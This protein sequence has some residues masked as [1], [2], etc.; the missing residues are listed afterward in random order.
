VAPAT[1]ERL[2][3]P[4]YDRLLHGPDTRT[5]E[6]IMERLSDE[7]RRRIP[8]GRISA[9]LALLGAAVGAP[10]ANEADLNPREALARSVV[11]SISHIVASGGGVILG[12]GAAIVLTGQPYAY[13]VRLDGPPDRRVRQGMELEGVDEPTARAHQADADRAWN[14]FGL[15]VLDRNPA[16]PRLYHLVIDSTA[17]PLDACS[18]LISR[19]ATVFWERSTPA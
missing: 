5:P 11:S 2:D 16:D 13:H 7:E 12:R 10:V 18:E 8:P 19:A 15:R 9:T 3:L 14:Q 17:L 4:F 6:R 1:A